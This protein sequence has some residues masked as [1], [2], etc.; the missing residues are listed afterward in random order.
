MALLSPPEGWEQQKVARDEKL[1]IVI[2]AILCFGLFFWMILWHVYGKQNP[3][4]TT[5]KV[6]PQEFLQLHDAFVEQHKIGTKNG[7]PVVMPPPGSDVVFLGRMWQWSPLVVLKKGEWYTFHL[8]STDVQHG[9]SLQPININFMVLPGYD[10]VLRFRPTE[11]GEYSVIC[12]EFCGIGHH[13]MIGKI[14]VI[15]DESELDQYGIE[16]TSN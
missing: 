12:N 2:A 13:N 1:W 9:F 11:A 16:R 10:Y 3:S 15:E 6:S 7:F 5:Y 8:S 14:W 4:Q